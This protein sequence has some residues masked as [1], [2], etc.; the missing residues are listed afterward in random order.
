[1][2][3]AAAILAGDV[4]PG[5]EWYQAIAVTTLC[6]RQEAWPPFLLLIFSH[7]VLAWQSC[8]GCSGTLFYHVLDFFLIQEIASGSMPLLIPIRQNDGDL[9]RQSHA[10]SC[11]YIH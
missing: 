6:L 1:M 7:F 8:G 10:L 5:L 4:L 3:V 11:E 9:N 2:N